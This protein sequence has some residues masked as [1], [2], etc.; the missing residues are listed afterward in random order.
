MKM[1]VFGA[2]GPTG[3]ILTRQALDEGHDVT[4]FTRH[5]DDFPSLGGALQVVGGDVGDLDAVEAAVAG[6]D[7][8]VSTLGVPFGR[9][10]VSV[11]S[12]GATNMVAAMGRHGVKRLIC[13]SS[14][15][16]SPD[17]EQEGGVI[18]RK[19][20]QPYVVKVLGRTVYD[21]M[22]RMEEILQ[23][24]PI[25]WTI[26]RP[27]GLFSHG[28][29]TDYRLAED[30]LSGRFTAREDLADCLLRLSTDRSFLQRAVAV[31]TVAVQPSMLQLVWREGIRKKS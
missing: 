29:V 17:P 4:A 20:M 30:H 25:D 2:N 10:P 18:F 11:Y 28:A 13:V 21:D 31:T 19:V 15:T 24:S 16:M 3:Q 22:R 8:V 1:L 9:D 5:P 12:T 6:Q 27:S 14:S 23:G 26:V 7:A